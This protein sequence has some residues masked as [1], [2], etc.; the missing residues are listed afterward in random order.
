MKLE[1]NQT[2]TKRH[3][4]LRLLLVEENM[5]YCYVNTCIYKHNLQW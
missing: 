4:A 2:K 5:G 1:F 3:D